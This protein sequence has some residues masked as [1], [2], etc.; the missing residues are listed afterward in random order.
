MTKYGPVATIKVASDLQKRLICP[1]F[2]HENH[3]LQIP[4]LP[5]QAD[6]KGILASAIYHDGKKI[7]NRFAVLPMEGWDAT[8][9]GKPSDLT[10]RRWQRFGTSGAKLIWGTEAVA[11]RH[12]GRANPNQLLLSDANLSP[13]ADLK[14]AMVDAH[15]AAF[16]SAFDLVVGLQ[17]THSGRFA[18]PNRKDLF[19]PLCVMENP[20]LD[21]RYNIQSAEHLATDDDLSRLIEDFVEASV[22]A[23]KAG[24]DFV[25]VKHC[26]GYLGHELLSARHRKGKFGGSLNNRMRFLREIV[27]GI[28]ARAPGLGIG[29][30]LS[31]FDSIPYKPG[32]DR[33]G[34]P[35]GQPEQY[36]MAFGLLNPQHGI[37]LAETIAFLQGC[38][39]MGVRWIC[40]TAGS[41]YST[42]HLQRPAQF[43]PSDGYFPPEDPCIG[44]T[45]QILATATLKQLFPEFLFVGSG[46]SFLQDWLPQVAQ[47]VVDAGMVDMVGLGRMILAYPDL[48]ADFLANKQLDRKR[49]C[50]TFS[51]CTTAPRKG[52]ISGCFPLDPFYRLMPEAEIVRSYRAKVGE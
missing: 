26:H 18:R 42:P 21:R 43:P 25:D 11:V 13:I 3:S 8:T 12:D 14:L 6:P 29:V 16:G 4:T 2:A 24:F 35:D 17:L 10:K 39:E 34:V 5:E 20:L 52:M 46:Y 44:V 19:E 49:V 40:T 7:G 41:P 23:Q 38:K 45:R 48:P 37:D 9:D 50:R 15:R 1:E 22:R 28:R 36:D 33:M 32:E 47:V 51:D 31:I 30:R 27:A